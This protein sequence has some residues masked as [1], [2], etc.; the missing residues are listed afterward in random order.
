[1]RRFT[2][3]LAMVFL[4]ALVA[5]MAVPTAVSAGGAN[6]VNGT[7]AFAIWDG[8]ES[9][10]VVNVG[11]TTT[12]LLVDYVVFALPCCGEPVAAG[13]GIVPTDSLR[14]EAFGVILDV[15]TSTV[16]GF[17][18]GSGSGGRITVRWER[19]GESWRETSGTSVLHI[20]G[21]HVTESGQFTAR[22]A[23]ASGSVV[24]YVVGTI[25]DAEIQRTHFVHVETG[26]AP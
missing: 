21:Y 15:D 7:Y 1:M 18:N 4:A 12:G 13:Q 6:V 17:D 9:F 22:S 26:T 3:A 20:G 5:L 11:E 14:N 23:T 10:G 8:P 19:T 16:Q 2:R 25:S 24:G